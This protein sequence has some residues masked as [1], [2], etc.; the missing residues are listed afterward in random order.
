M[1]ATLLVLFAAAL[2]LNLS[3]LRVQDYLVRRGYGDADSGST[4]GF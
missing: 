3:L 1:Y 4:F 2:V